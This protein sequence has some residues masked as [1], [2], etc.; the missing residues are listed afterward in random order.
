MVRKSDFQ[1]TFFS[2][3]LG[4]LENP[5]FSWLDYGSIMARLWNVANM[6]PRITPLHSLDTKVRVVCIKPMQRVFYRGYK[7]SYFLYIMQG[8]SLHYVGE[9]SYKISKKVYQVL[10]PR[11]FFEKPLDFLIL[12]IYAKTINV[13]FPIP[14]HNLFLPH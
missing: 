4:F 12:D 10:I 1:K 7:H 14:S 9:K 6:Q 13:H 8:P 2:D 11:V 3:F 5:I